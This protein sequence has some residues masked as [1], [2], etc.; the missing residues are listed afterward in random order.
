[1]MRVETAYPSEGPPRKVHGMGWIRDLPDARDYSPFHPEVRPLMEQMGLLKPGDSAADIRYLQTGA[2]PDHLSALPYPAVMD[3]APG[4]SPIE[5]Q[6]GL[7]S[8]A[9]FATIG[10]VEYMEKIA[11][12][13]Y[14]NASHLFQYWNARKLIGVTGDG[15]STMSSNMAAL[16]LFGVPPEVHWPYYVP[17]FNVQPD[18]FLYAY[19]SDFKGVKYLRIDKPGTGPGDILPWVKAFLYA[20]I[21]LMFGWTVYSEIDQA[22]TTGKVPFP[23]LKT[24]KIRGGHGVDC[25]GCDDNMVIKNTATGKVTTGAIKFRNSWGPKWGQAGYGFLPY[26]YLNAGLTADWWVLQGQAYVDTGQFGVKT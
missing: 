13:N 15:G 10:L 18:A 12:G 23:D 7:G 4:C 17:N 19:A 26:D 6:D 11:F 2:A 8:C 3:L 1:M 16:V 24:S 9:T 21:P 22:A 5:D 25:V 20:K 14:L